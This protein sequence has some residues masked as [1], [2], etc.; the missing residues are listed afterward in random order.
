MQ[1][2]ASQSVDMYG[3]WHKF[4]LCISVQE[5]QPLEEFQLDLGLHSRNLYPS[6]VTQILEMMSFC[7]HLLAHQVLVLGVHKGVETF[8]VHLEIKIG[9]QHFQREASLMMKTCL[10]EWMSQDLTYLAQ[11]LMP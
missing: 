9:L 11:E 1:T 10:V 3:Y 7:S 5:S 8:S 4:A 6:S 2:L